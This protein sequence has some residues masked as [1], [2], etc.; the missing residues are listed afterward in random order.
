MEIYIVQDAEFTDEYRDNIG[1]EILF[2]TT[3][4]EKAIQFCKN[5]MKEECLL[6]ITNP[7]LITNLSE[8]RIKEENSKILKHIEEDFGNYH[9]SS[10]FEDYY[11]YYDK[12]TVED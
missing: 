7:Q 9:N 3:S 4:E 6:D 1:G 10:F 5:K 11:V 2:V 8:E 12:Y